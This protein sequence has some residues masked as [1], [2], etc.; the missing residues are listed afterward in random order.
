LTDVCIGVPE[1]VFV[2]DTL[3]H[4]YKTEN[5]YYEC[6]AMNIEK[7]IEDIL[8]VYHSTVIQPTRNVWKDPGD[9]DAMLRR[10]FA[11]ADMSMHTYVFYNYQINDT[12]TVDG[13]CPDFLDLVVATEYFP[14]HD[15]KFVGTLPKHIV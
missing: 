3:G 15:W 8:Y 12:I 13:A 2:T 6:V 7:D 14:V 11:I 10:P 9:D 5:V 4:V 1:F